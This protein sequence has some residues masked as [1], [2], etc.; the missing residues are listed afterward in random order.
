MLLLTAL[1]LVVIALV[2]SARS[3]RRLDGRLELVL[4]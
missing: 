2:H 1:V 3:G 4:A